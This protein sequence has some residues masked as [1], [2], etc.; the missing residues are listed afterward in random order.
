VTYGS[1]RAPKSRGGFVSLDQWN[2]REGAGGR[3][4]KIGRALF[5]VGLGAWLAFT[6]LALSEQTS[7][8]SEYR[9]KATFLSNFA[10]FVEWP[11]NAYSSPQAPLL[12]CVF[13]DYLFGTSLSTSTQSM[14]PH[15]RRMEVRWAHKEQELHGCQ[16]LF[17]SRADAKRYTKV[18]E[19]VRGDS[20]L[21]VGETPD[22]LEAGGAITFS[23][24]EEVLQ[25]EINLGAV[26]GARL[27]M[28]SRLLSLARRVVNKAGE[29][30]S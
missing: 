3:P 11:A 12:I 15:G 8:T 18:L 22:F 27:K 28:S 16:I 20:V 1:K 10:N 4:E 23:F 9:M 24:R 30:K 5:A 17:I 13:G 19:A 14:T 26:D 7:T 6:P 21:T 25:F 2:R 29:A